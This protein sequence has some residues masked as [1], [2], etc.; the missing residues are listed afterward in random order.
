MNKDILYKVAEKVNAKRRREVL[1]I[2]RNSSVFDFIKNTRKSG[3]FQEGKK[4][5]VRMRKVATVPV[6][7][8]V[9]FSR[10]Y[11]ADYYKNPDFFT[12]MHQEWR[13]VDPNIFGSEE[14]NIKQ[15]AQGFSND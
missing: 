10:L 9:F 8:D 2:Y 11:G 15:I 14:D 13:V 4:D 7:V 3:E 5:G 12:K 6:E 1:S